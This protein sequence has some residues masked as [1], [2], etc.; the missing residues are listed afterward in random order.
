MLEVPVE[1]TSSGKLW[2]G[3]VQLE[4]SPTLLCVYRTTACMKTSLS[5]SS[6]YSA[7]PIQPT[8]LHRFSSFPFVWIIIYLYFFVCVCVCVCR[9]FST[10]SRQSSRRA[11]P[12]NFP[13]GRFVSTQLLGRPSNTHTHTQDLQYVYHRGHSMLTFSKRRGHYCK[14]SPLALALWRK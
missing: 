12:H 10:L 9:T 11:P 4:I 14:W 3:L 7:N 6:R 5:P 2:D 8:N 1:E 13:F